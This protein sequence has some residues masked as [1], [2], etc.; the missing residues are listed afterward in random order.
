MENQN[1]L[2]I[3]QGM[4]KK[5]LFSPDDNQFLFQQAGPMANEKISGKPLINLRNAEALKLKLKSS[6]KEKNSALE[7][8]SVNETSS[9]FHNEKKK[10]AGVQLETGE[11]IL[12]KTVILTTGTFLNGLIHIGEI[13]YPAGRLGEFASTGLSESLIKAGFEVGR[14]KTGTVAR[15]NAK[16]IN[17]EKCIEQKPNETP[18]NFSYFTEREFKLPQVSCWITYTNEKTHHIIKTSLHRSPLYS[19]RI[20]GIGPRYCPSIEDKVNRFP[21]RARHPVFVEPEGFDTNEIYLQG[22]STSLPVDIQINMLRSIDG[23]ESV[24]LMRPGYAIEYDFVN[25]IQ[26]YSNLMTKLVE[27]L[28]MAGQINGTSGYEEAA[29]QGLLA[30]INATSYIKGTQPLEIK[31]SEGYIGVLIDDLV[32]KG[33]IEPYRIFTSR[34]EH[35]LS[36]RFDN[37]DDRLS[38]YGYRYGLLTDSEFERICKMRKERQKLA[39]DLKVF[40]VK[41]KGIRNLN[42][43]K[44]IGKSL[45]EALKDPKIIIEDIISDMSFEANGSQDNCQR[46]ETEIKYEG[47]IN[48]QRI[49]LKEMASLENM[50]IPQD[51]NYND[52][53]GIS[54][55]SRIKLE[56]VM[57]KT[58]AQASGISGVSPSDIA[59]LIYNLKKKN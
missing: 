33:T 15:V 2:S 47:Y 49:H 39:S 38:E 17:F 36:V 34:V 1:N 40:H 59:V 7:P 55:E 4:V 27:G 22:L 29:P 5:L 24:E 42:F 43:E 6:T 23:L 54:T 51:L 10:I 12:S 8:E 53:L 45:Y 52:I 37:A 16:T 31:R 9:A 41:H 26:L 30:G 3:R 19:G 35:R 58:I 13:N 21:D 48:K 50:R 44:H 28:F 18:L 56:K 46:V 32:T 20:I 25:P 11:V 57:P 14:L